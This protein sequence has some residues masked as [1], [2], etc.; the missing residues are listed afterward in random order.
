MTSLKISTTEELLAVLPHQVGYHLEDCVTILMVTDKIVGPV[1]RTDLPPERH[2][3]EA[4]ATVLESVLRVEPQLALLVAY[5]SVPG[6]SRTLMRALHDGLLLAGVQL[7]DH[8]VVRNGH[9]W[10]WC[11]RPAGSLDGILR[12]HLDGH[13]MADSAAVPAV[14]EFIARGSAPLADRTAMS[15]LVTED[16]L[17]SEG[18]GDALEALWDTCW[19]TV[20][21]D[22]VL[23]TAGTADAEDAAD[24]DEADVDSEAR[25][26]ARG[27]A[28]ALARERCAAY[29]AG[30]E[31]V[32]HLW[33]RVLAPEGDR[34]D[35]FEAT[36]DEVA[37]LA[38][39]LIHKPWRDALIAWLSPVMFPLD[40]V[41]EEFVE[42]LGQHATTGPAVTSERS[43][44]ALRRLLRLAQRV[45]D[46]W[47]GEAA[48][49]CTVAAC[50]AW[51]LGNG[52]T[53]GDGVARA[54][55]L[56]P[57]YTLAGYLRRMIEFQL[58]PRQAWSDVAA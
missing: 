42:L 10:G 44:T 25:D 15:A 6:E 23:D 21:P 13:P 55:R 41:D 38:H 16:R 49:I 35:T 34:G 48:A 14:S 5:E 36:D 47:S 17:V 26:L 12:N 45:P 50:V 32:P 27:L 30:V 51:G 57:G 29:V 43:Q 18:V 19:A 37:R 7:I 22:G 2:A 54:L 20:D 8:V 28:R 52:S 58:R 4:A 56:Q 9:W 31:R 11:C 40:Q 46:D 33:A 3:L 53:A 1:A 24:F 39:S